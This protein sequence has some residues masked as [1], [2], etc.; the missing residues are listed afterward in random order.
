MS[1]GVT[2]LVCVGAVGAII[3]GAAGVMTIAGAIAA[4]KAAAAAKK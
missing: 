2:V 3:A 1:K 4:R